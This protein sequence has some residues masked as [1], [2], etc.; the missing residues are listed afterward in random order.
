MIESDADRLTYLQAFGVVA[1]TDRGELLGIFDRDYAAA[2]DVEV[3]VPMLECRTSDVARLK[4]AKGTPVMIDGSAFT[5]RRAEPEGTG[6]T[7]LV[8]GE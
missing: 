7:K 6:M 3:R 2:D 1:S 8:L 4:V 5:V